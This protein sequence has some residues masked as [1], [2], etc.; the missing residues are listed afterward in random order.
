MPEN[1]PEK[2]GFLQEDVNMNSSMRLMCFLSLIA[3]IGFGTVTLLHPA[4]EGST[5]LLMTM[6]FLLGAF[7][8]KALQK[9][10]EEKIP[11]AVK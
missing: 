8:P 4:T 5:G 6:G 1:E 11:G 2:I 9:F 10:M 3:A 7:A